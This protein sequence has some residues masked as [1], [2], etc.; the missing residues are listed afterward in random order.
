MK[1]N[2]LTL[3]SDVNAFD[4]CHTIETEMKAFPH[5]R[6]FITLVRESTSILYCATLTS[7][8]VSKSEAETLYDV[9]EHV[10]TYEAEKEFLDFETNLF[11]EETIEEIHSLI[12][13]NCLRKLP[14]QTEL[15]VDLLDT[16]IK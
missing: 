11:F 16:Y 3:P 15:L 9:L 5:K 7:V 8:A 2:I 6:C 12:A 4:L 13:N 14:K 10:R 1:A